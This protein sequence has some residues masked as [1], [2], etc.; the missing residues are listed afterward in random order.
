MFTKIFLGICKI[1]RLYSI[2]EKN[3]LCT[4]KHFELDVTLSMFCY[5][6]GKL[7]PRTRCALFLSNFSCYWE[8][9]CQKWAASKNGQVVQFFW[10]SPFFKNGQLSIFEIQCKFELSQCDFFGEKII[11][12]PFLGTAA[13]FEKLAAL[14]AARA[15][16]RVSGFFL[17]FMML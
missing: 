10:A 4:L 16:P 8:R 17:G 2:Q 12:S 6:R 9:S 13:H 7:T 15:L 5:I 14:R 1:W 3:C 11:T